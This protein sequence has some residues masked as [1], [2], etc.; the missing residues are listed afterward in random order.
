MGDR[1]AWRYCM[2]PRNGQ[3]LPV[4]GDGLAHSKQAFGRSSRDGSW[5]SDLELVP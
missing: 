5:I 3:W 4:D 2:R 1:A